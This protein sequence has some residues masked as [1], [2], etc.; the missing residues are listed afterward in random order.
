MPSQSL[1]THLI[2]LLGDAERLDDSRRHLRE[3][4]GA[5]PDRIYALNRA[6][7][8]ACISAWEAYVE[9]LAREAVARLRPG[10]ILDPV[11]AV[12]TA[13][14]DDILSRFNTPNPDQVRRLLRD[15]IGL[16]DIR[17]FWTWRRADAAWVKARLDEI[18]TLRHQIAHGVNPRP[19]VPARY[20]GELPDFFRRLG[21]CTDAAVRAHLAGPLG[22]PAPWPA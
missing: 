15:T 16:S 8:V 17:P 11:W 1:S 22:I 21:R 18:I 2:A 6:V 14:G 9:A 5:T 12:L 3:T 7:V 13:P 4:G 20:V 10:G 19:V